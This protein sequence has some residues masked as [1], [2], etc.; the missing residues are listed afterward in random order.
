MISTGYIAVHSGLN[1]ILCGIVAF[2]G[3]IVLDNTLFFISAKGRKLSKKL[4]KK[5]NAEWLTKAQEKLKQ[6]ATKT[7]FI[8][9][10]IPNLRFFCPIIAGI[11]EI[12]WKLFFLINGVATLSY[13]IVYLII[14]IVLQHP[15]SR[16]MRKIDFA[17]HVIFILVM[18]AITV[19][20]TWKAQ[21]TIFKKAE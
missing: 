13:T 1:P 16:I 15:L 3:L 5:V 21:K 4:L 12:R 6:N 18:L 20:L 7:L 14:G 8:S 11:S 9:A 17:H 10:L 19:Y 2:T